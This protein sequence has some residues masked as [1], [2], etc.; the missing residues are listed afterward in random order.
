M[1]RLR[2]LGAFVIIATGIGGATSAQAN[3]MVVGNAILIQRDVEGAFSD[4]DWT[5][6]NKGDDVFEAEF[7]RTGVN[8]RASFALLDGS[9]IGFGATVIM[10][11]DSVV[12]DPHNHSIQKLIVSAKE[13]A[14]RWIGGNSMSSAYQIDTPHAATEGSA[15]R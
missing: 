15:V 5:Q 8:S 10:K 1:H 12:L 7:I 6:T 13:G 3:N 9:T 14:V 4:Q 11:L 2:P